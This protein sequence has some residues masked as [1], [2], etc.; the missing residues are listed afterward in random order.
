[1]GTISPTSLSCHEKKNV[2]YLMQQLM[3]KHTMGVSFPIMIL[4]Y[5][6]KVNSGVKAES[7]E[8][9]NTAAEVDSAEEKTDGMGGVISTWLRNDS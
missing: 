9:F 8:R 1:M 7:R 3:G 6:P 5:F 2:K 4:L